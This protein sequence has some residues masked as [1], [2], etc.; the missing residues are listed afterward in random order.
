MV[1]ILVPQG[2]SITGQTLI[3]ADVHVGFYAL[4]LLD[5]ATSMGDLKLSLQLGLLLAR[6]VVDSS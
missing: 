5:K 4:L 2:W 6:Y 1:I 3:F